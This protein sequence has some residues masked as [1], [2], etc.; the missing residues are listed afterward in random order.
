MFQLFLSQLSRL[1]CDA[2]NKLEQHE[3]LCSEIWYVQ[4]SQ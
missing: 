1:N 2:A 4:Y 3:F